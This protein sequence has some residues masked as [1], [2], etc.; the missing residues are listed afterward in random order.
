[1]GEN[2]FVVEVS[3]FGVEIFSVEVGVF[4]TGVDVAGDGA[5]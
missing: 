1:M 5:V 3:E 2:D 4:F